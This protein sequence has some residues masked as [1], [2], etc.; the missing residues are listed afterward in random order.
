MQKAS[1]ESQTNPL[2]RL[3]RLSNYKIFARFL[4]H[5]EEILA[6][7]FT[8]FLSTNQIFKTGQKFR[9]SSR[10]NRGWSSDLHETAKTILHH[11]LNFQNEQ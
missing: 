11:L 4:H 1:T 6:S 9:N 5:Q 3:K 7:F 2:L 10:E 8:H